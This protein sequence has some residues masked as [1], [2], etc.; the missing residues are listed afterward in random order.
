MNCP[1][2]EGRGYIPVFMM[3]RARVEGANGNRMV[4]CD[5]EG[6]HCGQ[7]HCCDGDRPNGSDD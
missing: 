1:K 4:P 3:E 2:C 5:F 7:V 6:C